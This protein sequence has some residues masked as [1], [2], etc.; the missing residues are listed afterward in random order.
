MS[1]QTE[2]FAELL[3]KYLASDGGRL[4]LTES[5]RYPFEVHLQSKSV[6][7]LR[8][9]LHYAYLVLA[10]MAKESQEPPPWF[11]HQVREAEDLVYREF[12]EG[13]PVE[14]LDVKA[15]WTSEQVENLNEYQVSGFFHPFTSMDGLTLIA[16]EAGWVEEA[17][18]R[19]VQDW[20]HKWMAD[21]SWRTM[22][23]VNKAISE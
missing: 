23:A 6:K 14:D 12:G 8:G 2:L 21:G 17:G 3:Q 15:P 18:G 5:M 4:R 13:A 16:T 10:H 19:V 20:A 22:L 11:R 1:L 7:E 9:V